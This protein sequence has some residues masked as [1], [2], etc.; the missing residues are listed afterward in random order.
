MPTTKN[1]KIF[2]AYSL[3]FGIIAGFCISAIL[4]AIAVPSIS[5]FLLTVQEHTDFTILASQVDH[6]QIFINLGIGAGFVY[7]LLL[8]PILNPNITPELLKQPAKL[9]KIAVYIVVALIVTIGLS[10]RL[11]TFFG[12]MNSSLFMKIVGVSIPVVWW[13]ILGEIGIAGDFSTWKPKHN[14]DVRTCILLAITGYFIFMILTVTN[15]WGFLWFFT[16]VSEVLDGSGEIS[17]VGFRWLRGGIILLS[18]FSS[19]AITAT[20]IAVAPVKRE[21]YQRTDKLILPIGIT[22]CFALLLSGGHYYAAS[23]YDLGKRSLAEAIGALNTT[24][25]TNQKSAILLSDSITSSPWNARIPTY[26]MTGSST[27]LA[28]KE[29]VQLLVNYLQNHPQ[30]THRYSAEDTLVK[31]QFNLWDNASA[32]EIQQQTQTNV[33]QRLIFLNRLSCLTITDE[34]R[35]FLLNYEDDGRWWVGHKAALRLASAAIHFNEFAKAKQ[36]LDVAQAQGASD[37]AIARIVIPE[38]RNLDTGKIVGS[39]TTNQPVTIGLFRARTDDATFAVTLD[40]TYLSLNLVDSIAINS[41]TAF[42]FTN[43]GTGK[44]FLA[45]KYTGDIA[46]ITIDNQNVLELNQQQQM[47]HVGRIIIDN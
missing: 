6:V 30:S 43:L 47:V 21:L 24:E 44:Y 35:R 5:G 3:V 46:H 32:T 36:W 31:I 15:N 29:N 11:D 42:S 1:E 40:T 19:I 23:H 13:S 27:L 10:Q 28:S 41:S 8:L 45:L 16:L 18:T 14:P 37:E 39:I 25:P 26:S 7:L 20:I 17:V 38:Q 4:Q 12:N 34:N 33:I 22:I 2:L 9:I